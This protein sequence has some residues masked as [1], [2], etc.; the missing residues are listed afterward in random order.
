MTRK[1]YAL[2]AAVS[3]LVLVASVSVLASKLV[4]FYKEHPTKHWIF[5]ELDS[6]AFTYAGR[7][8]T[9]TDEKDEAG[10]RFL[11]LSYGD[12]K[13][14]LRVT[15]PHR[16]F[17]ALASQGLAAHRDWLRVFRFAEVSGMDADD[18]MGEMRKGNITDRLAIVTRSPRAGVD[19]S[20]WGESWRKDWSFEF[21]E[22]LPAGGF[23]RKRLHYPTNKRGEPAKPGE[24]VEGTW[25]FDAALLA[26]PKSG[27]PNQQFINT[28]FKA[29]GWTF[30]AACLS[31]VAFVVSLVMAAYRPR[32]RP[33]PA[34]RPA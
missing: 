31:S 6:R 18:A 26:M 9:L 21:F 16:Q 2:I 32:P 30:P 7:T 10:T 33:L 23:E 5:Q 34:P 24:L 3:A 17:E 22:F 19:P 1:T 15:I 4:T 13:L 27:V 8:V 11:N 12:E 29:M 14:R 28:G 20:T 25:E